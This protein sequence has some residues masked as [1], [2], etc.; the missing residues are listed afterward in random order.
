[1]LQWPP[2]LSRLSE[3]FQDPGPLRAFSPSLRR[4]PPSCACPHIDFDCL[5]E[6]R[7]EF[8][9]SRCWPPVRKTHFP[10]GEL[11]PSC[12]FHLF[13]NAFIALL[14]TF[15]DAFAFE[16]KFIPPYLALLGRLPSLPALLFFVLP[17]VE[18]LARDFDVDGIFFDSLGWQ[19]NWPAKTE[20]SA[21]FSPAEYSRGVLTIADRVRETIQRIEP[22]AVVIG[23]NTSGALPRHAHRGLSA[24][25]AWL[26][27]QNH[28][29]VLASPVRL[30]IPEANIYSKGKNR[31]EMNQIFAA[32]HNLALANLHFPEASYI[33]QLVRIR[34]QFKDALLYGH[35]LSSHVQVMRT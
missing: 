19:M 32:G 23:E 34:Q 8:L 26:A 30:G 16:N 6:T 28:C 27:G 33:R 29:R 11:G 1:M 31:N 20:Q 22:D 5:L 3:H 18:R 21:L 7:R 15:A 13:G 17:F 2:R 24:D 4:I 12:C 35:Q 10:F 14:C 9:Q 25:F